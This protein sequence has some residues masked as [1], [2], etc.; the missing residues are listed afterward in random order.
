MSTAEYN[1]INYEDCLTPAPPI[2]ESSFSII[3]ITIIP[4]IIGGI[5]K[6]INIPFELSNL[7]YEI[8]PQAGLLDAVGAWGDYEDI[9][10]FIDD[11]YKKRE[12]SFDRAVDI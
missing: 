3:P 5:V 12:K 8:K 7:T 11:V 6:T 10:G 1:L 2:S 4:D 9:D